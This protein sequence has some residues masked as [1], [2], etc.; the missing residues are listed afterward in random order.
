LLGFG[1]P[2]L[3]TGDFGNFWLKSNADGVET[4]EEVRGN[5]ITSIMPR[6]IPGK[7][8]KRT[9]DTTQFEKLPSS[10]N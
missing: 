10:G 2:A 9:L 6:F 7:E 8:F 1:K 3:R 5:Q 4:A